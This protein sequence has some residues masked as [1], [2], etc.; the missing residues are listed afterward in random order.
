MDYRGM[1]FGNRIPFRIKTHQIFL[2]L[3]VWEDCNIFLCA[4]AYY[5][6]LWHSCNISFHPMTKNHTNFLSDFE[7]SKSM[8]T[9]AYSYSFSYI[10]ILHF[11]IF[12]FFHH[13][14]RLSLSPFQ[15]KSDFFRI[16]YTWRAFNFYTCNLT[17][18]DFSKVRAVVRDFKV[19]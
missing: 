19:L 6:I 8:L 15:S 2:L 17:A 18:I 9:Y 4:F 5:C 13:R 7:I 11:Y 16:L 3:L 10:F 1:V 14:K 12:I